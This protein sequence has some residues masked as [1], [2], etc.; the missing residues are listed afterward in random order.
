MVFFWFG[1]FV[2]VFEV[3]VFV[4]KFVVLVVFWVEIIILFFWVGVCW[5]VVKVVKFVV[6]KDVVIIKCE[7]FMVLVFL[8]FIDKNSLDWLL[9]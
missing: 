4:F 3:G 1:C 9:Y 8:Y 6:V 7:S 2:D 5:G